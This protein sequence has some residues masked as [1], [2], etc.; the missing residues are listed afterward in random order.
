DPATRPLIQIC[1]L[2]TGS[3]QQGRAVVFIGELGRIQSFPPV[4]GKKL[5][6]ELLVQIGGVKVVQKIHIVF[7]PVSDQ[8]TVQ[9]TRP[10]HASF[11]KSKSKLRK[12]A[13]DTPPQK[14]T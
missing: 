1:R 3:P 13:G 14:D 12:K 7:L 10:A 6:H 2:F 4:L 5:V 8:V 9:T 11:Q